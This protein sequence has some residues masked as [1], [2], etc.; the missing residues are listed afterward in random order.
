MVNFCWNWAFS[1]INSKI[2]TFSSIHIDHKGFR[3]YCR[4]FFFSSKS[5][6]SSAKNSNLTKI[7]A[8]T[9]WNCCE[10]NTRNRYPLIWTLAWWTDVQNNLLPVI[11]RLWNSIILTTVQ[12][13]G[14][15]YA[16]LNI[17][18]QNFAKNIL[19]LRKCKKHNKTKFWYIFFTAINICSNVG[20]V[21]KIEEHVLKIWKYDALLC[22][23]F[24]FLQINYR[25]FSR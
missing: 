2:Y 10:R 4:Q 21:F 25:I 14:C 12:F 6:L 17:M 19:K 13:C 8:H 18:C 23:A 1:R 22:F 15:Y 9:D 5:N 24:F 16:K 7:I 3:Q 11:S 20:C